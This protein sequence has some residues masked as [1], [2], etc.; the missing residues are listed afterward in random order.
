LLQATSSSLRLAK[1]RSQKTPPDTLR[2]RA[3]GRL[4][5]LMFLVLRY[6]ARPAEGCSARP[7][8]QDWKNN[9]QPPVA[10]T[11][12]TWVA[13]EPQDVVGAVR[14]LEPPVPE[15][16]HLTPV[17]FPSRRHSVGVVLGARTM[18]WTHRSPR[19]VPPA[20]SHALHRSPAAPLARSYT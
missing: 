2:I 12:G 10:S 13:Q 19:C 18:G 6:G 1:L 7:P 15:G 3:M 17:P 8:A 20:S 5:I 4:L 11:N 9:R 14:H 16:L